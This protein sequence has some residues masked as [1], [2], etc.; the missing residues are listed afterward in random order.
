MDWPWL[1]TCLCSILYIYDSVNGNLM[2]WST[3]LVQ[4]AIN[5]TFSYC[6]NCWDLRHL[7]SLVTLLPSGCCCSTTRLQTSFEKVLFW[8]LDYSFIH[9]FNLCFYVW[10]KRTTSVISSYNLVPDNDTKSWSSHDREEK[11]SLI[12][13]FFQSY[14]SASLWC[15]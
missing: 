8:W 10:H 13:R 11:F 12:C 6:L 14:T 9:S 4:P 5:K 2:C 3:C 1:V 15:V 7:L